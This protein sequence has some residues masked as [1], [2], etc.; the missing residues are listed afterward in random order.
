MERSKQLILSAVKDEF[1]ACIGAQNIA[2]F[3]SVATSQVAKPLKTATA[4]GIARAL[5]NSAA[6]ATI[7]ESH[8]SFGEIFAWMEAGKRD[9]D[10]GPWI[11]DCR[12]AFAAKT[13]GIRTI[14]TEN[15]EDFADF[16][17]IEAI[18]PFVDP[19]P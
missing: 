9:P 6:L 17:F 14:L 4:A 16:E 11:N 19:F 3:Y 18:N 7:Y 5:A 10:A 1:R 2:E 15:T 13:N 8:E 12:L